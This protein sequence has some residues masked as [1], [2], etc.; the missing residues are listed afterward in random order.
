MEDASEPPRK[1][2][3][4]LVARQQTSHPVAIQG[5]QSEMNKYLIEIRN[6][7][8]VP[9][10]DALKFW[11]GR[12]ESYPRLVRLAQDL[13]CAPASQ[14]FVERIFFLRVASSLQG[15]ETECRSPSK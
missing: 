10:H 4:C 12:R 11:S 15:A 14:A 7:A 2:W 13:V 6:S 3:K 8:A 9:A 5:P 1:K